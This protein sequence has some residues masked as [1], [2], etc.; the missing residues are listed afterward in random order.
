MLKAGNCKH[1]TPC[2]YEIRNTVTGRVYVGST[3]RFSRRFTEHKRLLNANK[4]HSRKLQF[5]YNKHGASAFVMKVIEVVSHPAFIYAREQFWIEKHGFKNTYNSAPVAMG[6]TRIAEAVYSIDPKTGD[7][8]KFVSAMNAAE[9]K[10][11]SSEKMCQIRTAIYTRRKAGGVFWTKD[12]NESIEEFMANKKQLKSNRRAYCVFAWTMDGRLT[13]RFKSITDATNH[14]GLNASSMRRAIASRFKFTC[15]SMLWSSSEVPPKDS[16]IAER[17]SVLQASQIRRREREREA[18]RPKVF[19]K[20]VIQ[21]D[22]RSGKILAVH[23]SL[24][25][26]ARS[27]PKA[28]LNGVSEAANKKRAHHAGCIWEF[29]K[30]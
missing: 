6:A 2:I 23:P 17:M 7:K 29:A 4:H 8:V 16:E 9:M 30:N 10:L 18:Q 20:P 25:D 27:V 14:Y 22:R 13:G 19:K 21:I 28:T 1:G 11:G 5:S 3:P 26:A 24:S 12:G 15:G